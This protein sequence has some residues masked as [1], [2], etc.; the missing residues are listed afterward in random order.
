MDTADPLHHLEVATTR[1]GPDD[2]A[3]EPYLLEE[4]L[5]L[6][7]A[8]AAHTVGAA[9]ANFL[10]A[11]T[12]TIER[13]KAADLV[14]LDRHLF[15]DDPGKIADARVLATLVDGEPVY[16]TIDGFADR[17]GIRATRPTP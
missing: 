14:I 16:S 10:D 3:R 13:G 1:V 12:G 8:I 9:Y 2:R 11:E 15:A 17:S 4:T 5:D 7:D 6:P